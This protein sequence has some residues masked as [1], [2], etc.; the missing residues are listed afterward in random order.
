MDDATPIA[1]VFGVF[2]GLVHFFS[3]SL[4]PP[5]GRARYRVVSLAAGISIAYLFLHLLP[6]TYEA[7]THLRQWVF[8]FLLLGFSGFHLVE[9]LI[10]Q[11]ADRTRLLRDLKEVH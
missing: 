6:E 4:N 1:L 2:L 11:H 10:Y 8:V 9:K 3:E 7:A 5:H